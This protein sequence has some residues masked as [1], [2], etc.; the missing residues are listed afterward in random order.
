MIYYGFDA[1]EVECARL[2]VQPHPYLARRILPR[3]VGGTTGVIPFHLY[4]ARGRSSAYRVSDSHVA[5]FGDDEHFRLEETVQV[6][7]TTL[8][9][10]AVAEDLH[11]PDVLK[12]DTQGSE[13]D[14]LR[15]AHTVLASAHLVE[16]EVAFTP[17]YT[18]R[19]LFHDV[20]KFFA[21]EGYELLYLSRHFS[22]R[23]KFYRG[24]ARGQLTWGDALFGRKADEL[25]DVSDDGLIRYALL[26]INYGHVDF[27][28]QLV[29]IYPQ[30]LDG[31]PAI[32]GH[33]ATEDHG[34]RLSRA[35]VAQG[36]KLAMLWLHARRDNRFNNDSDR[37][38]PVR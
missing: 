29:A 11:A 1:D 30:I 2:N 27:A 5:A 26:L 15:H 38:W 18:G 19:P 17:I 28:R 37:N 3:Y 23:K 25:R 35:L 16:V 33:F 21:E 10:V 20:A 24:P 36:D 4:A 6:H 22:Q 14:I 32:E 7:S 13:L 31:L 8:D 34:S 9:E 12:L